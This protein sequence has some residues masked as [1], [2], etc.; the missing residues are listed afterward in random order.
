MTS[1][2]GWG[3]RTDKHDNGREALRG[4]IPEAHDTSTTSSHTV[5][6]S[7]TQKP[8]R[9]RYTLTLMDPLTLLSST[10][11]RMACSIACVSDT[12]ATGAR[13]SNKLTGG[14]CTVALG[15]AHS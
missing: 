10:A 2:S 5:H 15:M 6:S 13:G 4:T 3:G 7:H 14:T 12:T 11:L 1:Q 9:R 8:A